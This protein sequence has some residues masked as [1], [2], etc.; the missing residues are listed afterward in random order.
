MITPDEPVCI[1]SPCERYRYT[2]FREVN[3]EGRGLTAFICLNPSTADATKDDPTVRRC[4]RFAR[5][6]GSRY[7][8]MLNVFAFRATDPRDMKAQHDPFGKDNWH[9]VQR[10]ARMADR[11]IAAWGVHGDWMNGDGIIR[12][13]M[14]GHMGSSYEKGQSDIALKCLGKTKAGHP[15]HPLYIKATQLLID[16]P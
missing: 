4:M 15:K 6:W 9:H 2:L 14:V 16:Y 10:I 7:F 11:V 8:C 3:P 5:D 13:A 1:F 12:A